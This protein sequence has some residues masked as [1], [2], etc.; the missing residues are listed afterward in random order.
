M[1]RYTFSCFQ[2]MICACG[3]ST[4]ADKLPPPESKSSSAK[5]RCCRK[6]LTWSRV[7]RSNAASETNAAVYFKESSQTVTS[8]FNSSQ[9]LSLLGKIPK[10]EPRGETTLKASV[11]INPD[12]AAKAAAIQESAAVF[13][14][15]AIRGF[16]VLRSLQKIKCVIK[17]QAILRGNL[18]RRQAIGSLRC[19]QAISKVQAIVKTRLANQFTGQLRS[20]EDGKVYMKK[21]YSCNSKHFSRM[22]LISNGFARKLLNSTPRSRRINIRCDACPSDPIW[23][24]LERWTSIASPGIGEQQF[25]AA[26]SEFRKT[27]SAGSNLVSSSHQNDTVVSNRDA[28]ECGTEISVTSTLDS[29]TS[30]D[31]DDGEIVFEIGSMEKYNYS[32]N[33][34]SLEVFCFS[35]RTERMVTTWEWENALQCGLDKPNSPRVAKLEERASQVQDEMQPKIN[36]IPV[37]NKSVQISTNVRR[38]TE[39]SKEKQQPKQPGGDL[40]TR[41]D[42]DSEGRNSTDHLLDESRKAKRRL[43]SGLVTPDDS[44]EPRPLPSYMQATESA[45]A[46]SVS[47]KATP[48]LYDMGKKVKKR[49]Y[50][51]RTST[52]QQG[53]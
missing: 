21:D 50:L 51:P 36:G 34:E 33:G 19:I 1:G 9:N 49:H 16:L 27:T 22:K 41:L 15:T 7:L 25:L 17:L 38:I 2:I 11:V 26:H 35:H 23:R 47:P 52:A 37:I 32:N 6:R 14:Q 4:G 43:S 53:S 24:W 10:E 20:L 3:G 39:D 18:V 31:F 8:S 12:T 44:D 40:S 42:S 29:P 30:L 13:I 46:K 48:D 5:F 28:S 45:R